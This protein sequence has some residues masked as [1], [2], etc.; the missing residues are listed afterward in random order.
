MAIAF[1]KIKISAAALLLVVGGLLIDARLLVWVLAAALVH[2]A[3]HAIA[4][5]ACKARVYEL[6]MEPWGFEMTAEGALSYGEEII[7]SA[8]GPV[9]SLVFAV[10]LSFAGRHFLLPGL[11][12]ASGISVV[13][14][15]FNALPVLPL[16]GGRVLLNAMTLA[17]GP[18]NAE[19]AVCITSLAVIFAMLV[20]GAAVLIKTQ[21]NFTLLLAGVWLFISYCKRNGIRLKLNNTKSELKT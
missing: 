20:A 19:R 8:A 4:L 6:R 15:V 10:L 1:G 5:M 7:T 3:G 13:F 12:F 18:Y 11:Y 21:T 16:D 17:F 9:V 14:F 2:E